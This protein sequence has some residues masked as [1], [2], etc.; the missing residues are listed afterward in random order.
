VT[1]TQHSREH[2]LLVVFPNL[3]RARQAEDDLEKAGVPREIIDVDREADRI[4]ALHA[5]MREELAESW[6]MPQAGV[7]MTKEGAR[8]FVLVAAVCIVV[9]VVIAAPFAFI[10]FGLSFWGRL[11]LLV[12]IG[13]A[14][15]ATVGIIAGPALASKR[16]EEPAAADR[17]TVMHIADDTPDIRAILARLDPIRIDEVAH[18]TL[19][20]GTVTTDSPPAAE[21][22]VEELRE[23]V[24]S[25]DFRRPS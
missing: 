2:E 24:D 23:G 22:T 16:P 11:I 13:V 4:T 6:V 15:G 5:E 7:A 8:G 25:D 14:F 17:G 1:D 20:R 9:A 3:E 10:D 21:A 18:G 12:G 19:P